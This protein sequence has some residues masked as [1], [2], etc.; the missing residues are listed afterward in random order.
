MS[1]QSA[2][3]GGHSEISAAAD[4]IASTVSEVRQ[5]GLIGAPR[6]RVWDVIADVDAHAEWWPDAIEVECDEI[7]EGCTYREVIKVPLGTAER[8]FEIEELDEPAEFRIH[9]VVSGAFVHLGFTD[10][11]GGTFVDASAG[12]DP[13]GPRYRVLDTLTGRLYW[14]GWL[15]RW[16]D[17][18][19]VRAA[20]RPTTED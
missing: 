10:A 3:L 17:A 13:I 6:E 5:Q 11:Q 2:L 14:R 15:R 7:G 4:R 18:L 1:G 16:F 8:R 19:E 20:Q 9:C 12:M